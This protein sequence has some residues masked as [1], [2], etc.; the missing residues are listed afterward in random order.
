MSDPWIC[1]NGRIVRASAVTISP[2]D[3]GVLY[4]DGLFET[5][6]AYGG[7]GF[8]AGAHLERL[9]ASAPVLRL[10]LPWTAAELGAA[11]EQALAANALADAYLRLTVLRGVGPPGPDPAL[12]GEPHYFV[13]A[14]P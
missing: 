9:A 3:H 14:R 7:G 5:M 6:R 8:S 11:V 12:C 4:G 10:E 13:V 1:W 2:L